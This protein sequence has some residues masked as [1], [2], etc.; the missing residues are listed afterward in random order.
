M[1]KVLSLFLAFALLLGGIATAQVKE[2]NEK[3]KERVALQEAA[4]A[5]ESK[6]FIKH[7]GASTYGS[8]AIE[9]M[10]DATYSNAPVG[11]TG[12]VTSNTGAG[13]MAAHLVE[14]F[15]YPIQSLRFFGIQAFHNGTAWAPMNDV[16]PY[17]FEIT[18]YEDNAGL[19]G[20]L[21]ATES[22]T[23]NHVNTD[24]LFASVYNVFY[25]D[26]V[27]AKAIKELPA[28]FWISIVN[29]NPD[30][31]F[32]WID[33]PAGLGSAAQY[34]SGA[35]AVSTDYD[36]FGI[37]IVPVL[38]DVAAPDAATSFTVTPGADGA[39]SADVSWTNPS[40][41]F[42]G[43]PLTELTKMELF[44]NEVSVYVNN[45]P[46]IGGDEDQNI[47]LALED[48]GFFTFRLVGTNTAGEGIS[49]SSIAYVG[50]DSPGAPTNI[51]LDKND[52]EVQLSWNAPVVG[53]NGAYFSG[54]DVTYD[55]VRYPGEVLV[56]DDQVG[57]TFTETLATPGNY[58]YKVI[59]S[60]AIG[61]GG[62]ANSN[63]LLFGDFIVYEM[64][65]GATIP[66]GWSAMG[67]GLTNW[68]IVPSANAGGAAN[69]LRLNWSPS[70]T[71]TSYFVSPVINTSTYYSVTLSYKDMFNDYNTYVK[72]IGVKTTVDGGAT[73]LV[74]NQ[75][76]MTNGNVNVGPRDNQFVIN[77]EHVGN[78][79]F[80]F[81]FFFDG[82]TFDIDYWY[83]DNVTL[84]GVLAVGANV[85][86]TVMEGTTPIEGAVVSVNS[87]NFTTNA[88]GVVTGFVLEGTDIPYAVNKFGYA[89]AT[90]TITVVDGVEQDV[91]VQ[92]VSL[93]TYEVVFNVMDADSNPEEALVS[94]MLDGVEVASGTAVGGTITF[95][96][97]PNGEYTY[98]VALQ[99]FITATGD[100]T[101]DGADVI[102]PDV[103]LVVDPNIIIGTGT[104]ANKPYPINA[105]YG[106]SYTQSIYLKSEIASMPMNITHIKYYF[107]GTSL[108]SSNNWTIYMGHTSKTAFAST[109]DWVPFTQLTQVY[110]AEF[111]S[112]TEPGWI[113]FDITDFEYNGI[114]NLVI[115]VDEN[116][117]AY[118]S[119]SDRF[120]CTAVDGNRSII[121]YN[122][123]TNP[124]PSTPPTANIAPEAFIPNT[125]L[126]AYPKP[127]ANVTFT[128]TDGA[129]P[130]EGA[131]VVVEDKNYT[132]IAN[133]TVTAYVGE[134]ADIPY[135]VNK[136]GF[137]EYAGTITVV[138]G[139]EQDVNVTMV[140]LAAYSVTFNIKNI[141]GD[142]LNATVTAY[143][144]GVQIDVQTAV[145]GV[146]V[147]TE[148]PI[149]TYTYD[150]DLEGYT[151]QLAQELIVDGDEIVDIE[152]I[153]I[154]AAPYGLNVN[155]NYSALSAE[156]IW[157][158]GESSFADSFE[159]G[160]FNA[161]G[162]YIQGP[163]TPGDDGPNPYWYV[164]DD[165]GG[166]AADGT[167]ICFSDWGYNIDTWIVSEDLLVT[168]STTLSFWWNTS[169]Y[170]HVDPNPNGS[171]HVK[172]STNGGANWTSIWTEEDA[173]VFTNWVWY[174][175]VLDLS[176]YAGLV[177]IA[178]NF[179]SN[180]GA[181][182]SL[183]NILFTDAPRKVGTI[184]V[185]NVPELPANGKSAK[186]AS[187][188]FTKAARSLIGY[189]VYLDDMVTPVNA[190][191]IT[192][193]SYLFE[194]L[195]LGNYTA[196]VKAV[197]TTGASE[198]VTIDFSTIQV[199]VSSETFANFIAYPNPF[200]NQITISNPAVVSR[201][202]V[203]NVLGQVVLNV[204]TNGAAQ[205]ETG[206]LSSGIYLVTFQA[207]NGERLVSKMIKK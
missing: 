115:A 27:P 6:A 54:A 96:G 198:L 4:K 90:G 41:T 103:V 61:V 149:G 83:I 69:E 196:G 22:A 43:D 192:G 88:E 26:Y 130:I 139:V 52:M 9:C 200:S 5:P 154:L 50:E 168:E 141:L 180:D 77:N 118:N 28:T 3:E 121:Y 162:D 13:Y 186:G 34:A 193:T 178:F 91:E 82:Y 133:G 46:V 144:N 164:T 166:A 202:V 135:T 100:V 38:A 173:G 45:A 116:Q 128:V 182:Y 21:L 181:T 92:L 129:D 36:A 142:N 47:N 108:S 74:V 42:G 109:T 79:N 105:Y 31:W 205:I 176:S 161:W 35:W 155:V 101:V 122:D 62:N 85:N 138:D 167:K 86:F 14:N 37:C 207:A 117:P 143:F 112:P 104:I 111:T 60:N 199:G 64:F 110:S 17:N 40:L 18:Y 171:M 59:A 65:D 119:S 8:K 114:D 89:E 189:N 203:T 56:S 84:T 32:M 185:S 66:T 190:E 150:V 113:E 152:L 99:G 78:P 126:T 57:L 140:A 97:I 11:F 158:S 184:A 102:V 63:T 169:Y 194:G 197:Y 73:W 76:T 75:E 51:V 55:V 67:L 81:A 39:M 87:S 68:S 1:K 134:G 2:V 48:A 25:W 106:Y 19:P 23:L 147:F 29:T 175:T 131:V 70:F 94:L 12:A 170:W 156:L 160:T 98:T 201:V 174:E 15:D 93:P 165:P 183:D 44:A 53:L 163:G 159:D 146:A 157:N 195:A 177:K 33:Q 72:T 148:V 107:N 137:E 10:T 49:V 127:G 136:F 24:A 30:A 7:D 125:I 153:E 191:P 145:D 123:S 206:N 188:T 80:Q 204:N 16:D 71:G 151:S 179:V 120:L 172:I 20:T 95:T 58:Y 187:Y 124:D 132:T